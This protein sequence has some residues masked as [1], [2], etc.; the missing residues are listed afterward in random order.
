MGGREGGRE[1]GRGRCDGM[2]GM[3]RE[4]RQDGMERKKRR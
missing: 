2:R 1:G 4:V 3:R